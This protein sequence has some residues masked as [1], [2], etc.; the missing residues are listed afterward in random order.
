MAQHVPHILELQ[1]LRLADAL[2][3]FRL[4]VFGNANA[5]EHDADKG[6]AHAGPGDHVQK[7]LV[8]AAAHG[9]HDLGVDDDVQRHRGDVVERRLPHADRGALLGVVGHQGGQGLGG[10]V[11]HGIADYIDHVEQ[12][13]DSDAVTLAGEEVEHAQNAGALD[14]PAQKHQRT[15]LAEGGVDP[16]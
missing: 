15:N 11:H 7:G 1:T 3:V 6:E 16:V 5:H 12:Q 14:Q 4:V 8:E 13:E 9:G 10:H 2:E